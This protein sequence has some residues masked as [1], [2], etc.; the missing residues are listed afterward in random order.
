MGINP[1]IAWVGALIDVHWNRASNHSYAHHPFP[2]VD[3]VCCHRRV[4]LKCIDVRSS[5]FLAFALRTQPMGGRLD[6]VCTGDFGSLPGL[7]GHRL[8]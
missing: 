5:V 3:R 7:R 2:H 6:A 4:R 8:G 1:P